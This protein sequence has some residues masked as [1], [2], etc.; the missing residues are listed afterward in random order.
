MSK[1]DFLNDILPALI[2]IVGMSA[3]IWYMSGWAYMD[4]IIQFGKWFISF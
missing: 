2:F 4:K 1:D 3:I